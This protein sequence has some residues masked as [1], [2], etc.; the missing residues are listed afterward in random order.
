MF[1]EQAIAFSLALQ[2]LQRKDERMSGAITY[3]SN[4]TINHL[5]SRLLTTEG[6]SDTVILTVV[7]QASVSVCVSLFRQQV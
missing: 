7:L 1:F 4:R 6:T 3:H 5:R 2:D